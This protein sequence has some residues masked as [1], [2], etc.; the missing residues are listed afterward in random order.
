MLSGN[1]ARFSRFARLCLSWL[2]L[3]SLGLQS[4][5]LLGIYFLVLLLLVCWLLT[6]KVGPLFP[7]YGCRLVAFCRILRELVGV[8]LFFI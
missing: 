4:D 5:G 8:L 6:V 2:R 3:E 1:C 7:C